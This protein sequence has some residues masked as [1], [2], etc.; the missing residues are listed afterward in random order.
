[1]TD[2]EQR[3]QCRHDAALRAGLAA[4]LLGSLAE[5]LHALVHQPGGQRGVAVPAVD[6]RPHPPVVDGG[7][8]V[9]G[10]ALQRLYQPLDGGCDL[11]ET[12]SECREILACYGVGHL[13]DR[14]QQGGG[15]R[16]DLDVHGDEPILVH[17]AQEVLHQL[18]VA[19]LDGSARIEPDPVVERVRRVGEHGRAAEALGDRGPGHGQHSRE[20]LRGRVLAPH[21]GVAQVREQLHGPSQGSVGSEGV[22]IECGQRG[23]Q[24]AQL[25]TRHAAWQLVRQLLPGLVLAPQVQDRVGLRQESAL[26]RDSE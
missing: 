19:E 8:A 7:I 25:A 10:H 24:R 1:M 15:A 16:L 5:A 20:G 11:L 23:N 22:R 6:V 14:Q 3:G 12:A 9:L 21:V 13:R 26:G 18:D 4:Q 2:P 17:A